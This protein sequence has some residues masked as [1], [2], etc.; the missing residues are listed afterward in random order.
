MAGVDLNDPEARFDLDDLGRPVVG[1]AGEHGGL[2]TCPGEC[3][4]DL[5][6][7]DGHAAAVAGT[8][9]DQRRGV[10]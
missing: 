5:A 9:L 10:Q 8:R 2:A 3:R 4:H 7:V 1:P 6:D